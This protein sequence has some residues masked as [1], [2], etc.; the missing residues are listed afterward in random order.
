MTISEERTRS[1]E[2]APDGDEDIDFSD[3]PE[4]DAAF[5]A[6]AELHTPGPVMGRY[7]RLDPDLLDWFHDREGPDYPTRINALL[8]EHM[9]R[10]GR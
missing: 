5:W 2:G 4:T 8:R 9:E 3:I 1:I 10:A 7:I 6:N